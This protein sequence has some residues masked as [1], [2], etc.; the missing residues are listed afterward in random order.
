M[1]LMVSSLSLHSLHLLFSCVLSIPPLIW[2]V[3][4]YYYHYYYYYYRILII[5]YY[6]HIVIFLWNYN[7]K[8][9]SYGYIVLLWII[10]II[11]LSYIIISYHY[12]VLLLY[13]YKII[14]I[15]LGVEGDLLEIVQEIWIWLYEQLVYAQHKIR[16]GE[17][18]AQSSLRFWD[19]SRSRYL[20]LTT[21]PS[22][23]QQKKR[24]CRIGDFAL[25]VD[26]W[27]KLK[28]SEKKDE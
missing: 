3:L 19:T 22:E 21:R 27:V 12:I 20:D 23:C 17:W 5:L 2:L 26:H 6:H 25:S 24:T 10:I 28:E 7:I 9:F 13:Y 4:Y 14:I 18:D 16:P 8:L 11:F 15:A 1:W